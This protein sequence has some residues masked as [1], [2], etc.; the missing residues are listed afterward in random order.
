[1]QKAHVRDY[2]GPGP[3][4]DPE[5]GGLSLTNLNAGVPFHLLESGKVAVSNG[6]L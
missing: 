4:R 3:D 1:M 5:N 2:G 6:N